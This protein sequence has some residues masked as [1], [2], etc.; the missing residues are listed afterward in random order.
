VA[1]DKP[2]D[3]ARSSAS[4]RTDRLVIFDA[5]AA[6]RVPHT[7]LA[8]LEWDGNEAWAR[9]THLSMRD[10]SCLLAEGRQTAELPDPR[11]AIRLT[12]WLDGSWATLTAR[13]VRHGRDEGGRVVELLFV[14]VPEEHYVRLLTL[15]RRS[16]GA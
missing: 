9:T 15:T 1:R 14:D 16:V 8:R 13:L 3:V 12:L 5:G 11:A 7:S 6:T 10:V 2:F 4:G